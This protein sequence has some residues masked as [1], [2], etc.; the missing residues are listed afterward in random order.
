LSG[1][2]VNR[3]YVRKLLKDI[4]E[5]L[6]IIYEDTVKDYEDLSR[7]EISEIRYYLIVVAEALIAL[8]NHIVRRQ[9]NVEIETPIHGLKILFEKKLVTEEEMIDIIGL[10]RL[11]NLLVHRY[12]VIDDKRIYMFI[13][14]DFKRVKCFLDR[15]V[16]QYGL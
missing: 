3:D 14:N 7:M 1:E 4:D 16:S 13:K 5:A 10:I 15:V 6:K 11:R 12:W 8:I 9:Y 2:I